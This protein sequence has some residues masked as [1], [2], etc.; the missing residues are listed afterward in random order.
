MAASRGMS[1]PPKKR[2]VI[3][4]PVVAYVVAICAMAAASFGTG[5]PLVACAAVLF[6]FSDLCVA[7]ERFVTSGFEN[8]LLGLPTYFGAQLLFAGALT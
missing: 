3:R 8:K 7:R 2:T 6:V 4:G 5:R 1:Q